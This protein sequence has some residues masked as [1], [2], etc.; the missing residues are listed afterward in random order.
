MILEFW[1]HQCRFS[2]QVVVVVVVAVVAVVVVV[3]DIEK[4]MTHGNVLSSI[5][6][7]GVQWC[8]GKKDV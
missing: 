1:V 5:A 2:V 7:F 3:V 6:Y 8:G 4:M